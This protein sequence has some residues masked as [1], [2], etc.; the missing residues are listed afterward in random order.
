MKKEIENNE[1]TPNLAFLYGFTYVYL[2]I[3]IGFLIWFSYTFN[4]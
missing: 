1:K 4:K 3:F 2:F